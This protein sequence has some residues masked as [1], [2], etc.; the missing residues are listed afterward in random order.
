M[1]SNYGTGEFIRASSASFDSF[2]LGTIGDPERY[3][4]FLVRFFSRASEAKYFLFA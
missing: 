2:L 3:A 4:R 1:V